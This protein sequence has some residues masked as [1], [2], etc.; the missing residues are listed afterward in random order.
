MRY[1]LT[2]TRGLIDKL[3]GNMLD[4][5]QVLEV[6]QGLTVDGSIQTQDLPLSLLLSLTS[7]TPQILLLHFNFADDIRIAFWTG[8][9]YKK[10]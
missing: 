10:E 8:S 5:A 2:H 7:L 9:Q 6:V 1:A 4:H 3:R